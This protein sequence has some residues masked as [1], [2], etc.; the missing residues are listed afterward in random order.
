MSMSTEKSRIFQERLRDAREYRGLSQGDLAE[1]ADL[2]SSSVS[3]FETGT[4]K[5][6]FDNLR[7]LADAL[8]VSTD[9]LLGRV[10]SPDQRA[11]SSDVLHRQFDGLS[12]E[13]Q[14]VAQG[15]INMLAEKA[16]GR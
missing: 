6:S 10:E 12:P 9:Y 11:S 15:F 13:Y 7:R 2:P 3:H 8:R 4:R 5:P 16:R 1:R 14:D